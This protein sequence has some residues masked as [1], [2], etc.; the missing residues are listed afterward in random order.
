MSEKTPDHTKLIFD[1][2][3]AQLIVPQ[4]TQNNV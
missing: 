2:L 3:R 4:D 1:I